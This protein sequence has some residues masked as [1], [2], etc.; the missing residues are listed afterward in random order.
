MKL[1]IDLLIPILSCIIV[2]KIFENKG[3]FLAIVFKFFVQAIVLLLEGSFTN[4]ISHGI[5]Y[6]VIYSIVTIIAICIFTFIEYAVFC[7][8]SSFVSYIII[9]AIIEFAMSFAL[10]FILRLI[11]IN[12]VLNLT[13]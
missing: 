13:F 12:R 11:V 4:F 5:G 3:V 10:I 2:Y 1:I 7:K 9:S 6:I 8:T